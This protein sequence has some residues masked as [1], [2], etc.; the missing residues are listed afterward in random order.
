MITEKKCRVCGVTKPVSGFYKHETGKDGYRNH[1]IECVAKRQKARALERKAKRRAQKALEDSLKTTRVCTCC[2]VEYPF[3]MFH[4]KEDGKFGISPRCKPCS[5]EYSKKKR[6]E[7]PEKNKLRCKAWY[8]RRSEEYKARQAEYRKA[9]KESRK[10]YV[11]KYYRENK[12]RLNE[13]SRQNYIA[14][15]AKYRKVAKMWREANRSL[16]NALSMKYHANKLSATPVW[17]SKEQLSEIND[18]YTAAHMFKL[19]TGTE[20]HVD[21]IVPLQGETVCGLHVPWNLQLL[22][23]DENLSKQHRYWP[24]MPEQ[25]NAKE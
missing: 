11:K 9:N 2:G 10:E 15:R 23:W 7:D 21:H 3:D 25:D 14:N 19:Y 5:S 22:P 8:G 24:D 1:C 20:Y 18:L 17:L 13:I 6:L 4:K 12:E 16:A